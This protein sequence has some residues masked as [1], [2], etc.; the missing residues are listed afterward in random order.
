M[1][2]RQFS[3][4]LALQIAATEKDP[5]ISHYWNETTELYGV[6]GTQNTADTKDDKWPQAT[7]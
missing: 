1:W 5:N 6:N 7:A 4:P 3:L 2:C